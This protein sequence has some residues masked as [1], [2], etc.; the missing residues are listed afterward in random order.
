MGVRI[1]Q[2]APNCQFPDNTIF[3]LNWM[4]LKPVWATARQ[5]LTTFPNSILEPQLS[6]LDINLSQIGLR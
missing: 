4:D 2:S 5:G 6:K 1:E 3:C